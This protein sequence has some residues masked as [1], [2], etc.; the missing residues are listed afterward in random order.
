ME[1]PHL[2]RASEILSRADA[3]TKKKRGRT[4]FDAIR[5]RQRL[6]QGVHDRC[7]AVVFA[8][9]KFSALKEVI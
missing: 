6:G 4:F 5:N 1:I 8:D 9:S 7:E 3:A 2:E